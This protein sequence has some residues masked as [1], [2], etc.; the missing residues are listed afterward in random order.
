MK[1]TTIIL[2]TILLNAC[3]TSKDT[4][5]NSNADTT[6]NTTKMGQDQTITLEYSAITRGSYKLVKVTSETILFQNARNEKAKTKKCTKEQWDKLLV[7]LKEIDLKE[8]PALEPPSKAHQYDGA[9]IG[10]FT[11][12]H[13]DATYRTMAFDA[14][15]PN[16]KIADIINEMLALTSV[17]E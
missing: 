14:G 2:I 15:N 11:V 9:P 10:S 13:N 5:S 8:I 4:A 7:M 6:I 16:K 12:V 3:G 1:T 17:K